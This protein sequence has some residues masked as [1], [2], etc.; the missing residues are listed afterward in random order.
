MFDAAALVS[1]EVVNEQV[2]AS[3][4]A[5][6]PRADH[7][8]ELTT[9]ALVAALAS[10]EPSRNEV[11]VIDGSV[12][13]QQQLLDSIPAL[14]TVY[15]L[16]PAKD[17][18]AQLSTLLAHSDSI[19]ALHLISH[20][21]EGAIQLQQNLFHPIFANPDEIQEQIRQEQDFYHNTIERYQIRKM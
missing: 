20:G 1:A 15:I 11:Y 18:V 4:P 13:N 3:E 5:N 21:S 14:A 17:G 2:E 6:E 12:E 9:E 7:H 16:D 8:A 10:G 19:D